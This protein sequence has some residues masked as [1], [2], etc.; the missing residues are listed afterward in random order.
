M[1]AEK[2]SPG[3]GFL[4]CWCG[5]NL[6]AL[7]DISHSLITDRVAQMSQGTDNPIVAPGAILSSQTHDQSFQVFV[8]PRAAWGLP[9]LG[10]IKLLG[11]Q[12]PMPREDRVGFGGGGIQGE[13]YVMAGL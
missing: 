6:M 7:E 13:E 5:G 2:F 11:D 3:G 9:L 4:A 1:R 10:A 8:D 12:L